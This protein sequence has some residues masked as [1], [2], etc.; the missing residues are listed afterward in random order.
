MKDLPSKLANKIPKPY[1]KDDSDEFTDEERPLIDNESTS[2][3]N[4]DGNTGSSS[5]RERLLLEK[6]E[7]LTQKLEE[8]QR[9]E[10]KTT[11][12]R[13][14]R[15]GSQMQMRSSLRA[16]PQPNQ[17]VESVQRYM[18]CVDAN[19]DNEVPLSLAPRSKP[20]QKPTNRARKSA[21]NFSFNSVHSPEDTTLG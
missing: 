8:T 14:Y 12:N 1:R 13:S 21:S 18:D 4:Q 10:G 6:I 9:F 16:T 19:D 7:Y 17:D 20:H 11:K 5:Q 2:L 15:N 3:V